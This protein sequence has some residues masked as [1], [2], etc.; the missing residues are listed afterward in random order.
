MIN[1][2]G[3]CIRI[4]ANGPFRMNTKLTMNVS[5]ICVSIFVKI[6][7]FQLSFS[8]NPKSSRIMPSI[9]IVV[10]QVARNYK[11]YVLKRLGVLIVPVL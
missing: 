6:N 1:S 2:I 8:L 10:K 4:A 11:R 7:G 5:I 3:I 9:R